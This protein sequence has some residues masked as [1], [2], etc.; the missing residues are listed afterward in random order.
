MASEKVW[1]SPGTKPGVFY[2]Y[3]VV[4]AA[5]F[6]MMVVFG[7][8]WA[9]GI[10]FKPLL[11]E[12][13]WTRATT[14]GALSLSSITYGLMAI[15]MGGLTDKLGP[16]TVMTLCGILL[17]LGYLLMSQISTTWQ[18]YLIFGVMIGIGLG[19]TSVPLMSTIV[20]WFVK[21]RTMM[22]GVIMSGVG[23]GTL[24]GAPAAN[25]LI[26]TYDWRTAYIILGSIVLIVVVLAA[27]LLRRDPAQM[28]QRPYGGKGEEEHRSTLGPKGFSLKEAVC[29]KQFWLAFGIAFCVGFSL[30]SIIVHIAPHATDLGIPS[31]SAANI[32]AT[33]GGA[34]VVG[35]VAL[36]SA[37]DRIGNRQVFIIGFILISAALFWLIPATPVWQLYLFAVIFG[38]AS[39]GM[40]SSQSPIIARL[41][42]LSSHG[43]ILGVIVLGFTTGGAV[44]PF[45]TGYIFDVT[46]SYQ[47]AFLVGAAI[48]VVGLILAVILR[49]I[50]AEVRI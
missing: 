16:R 28:G 14:S 7:I 40:G 8:Y 31:A 23:I 21:R 22:T 47:L 30:R 33:I 1:Q 24:I 13:G 19:G 36:G 41:F 34:T 4:V 3:V 29:T 49:P 42:G 35:M 20:R 48:S 10:F 12:F 9:F 45:L 18:L 43:L 38:F 25:W 11:T 26:A 44:G 27:Q 37:A 46:G 17:G 50:S 32:L 5:F 15:V 39:G 6:I 2:G